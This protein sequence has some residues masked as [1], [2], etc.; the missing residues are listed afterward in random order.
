MITLTATF[1]TYWHIGTGRG[2]GQGVDALTEKDP[3]GLPQVSGK[4]L[5]G[6]FRDA[7]YK[8]ETWDTLKKETTNTLFGTRIDSEDTPLSRHETTPGCLHFSAL[9]LPEEDRQA[10]LAEEDNQADLQTEAEQQ[11]SKSLIPLLYTTLASTA[12]DEKTGTAKNKSLRMTQVAVP[13]TVTGEISLI[14]DP[15][16]FTQEEVQNIIE[17]CSSLITHLG[18]HKTRGLGEVQWQIDSQNK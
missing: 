15:A 6:L 4:M 1:Q 8:L 11:P 2:A 13:L 16:P 18:A 17:Q 7:C 12:I 14:K 5:K 9:R 10:L 3:N